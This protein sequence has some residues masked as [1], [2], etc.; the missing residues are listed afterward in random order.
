M[1]DFNLSCN[2][3]VIFSNYLFSGH[4]V[5]VEID[6]VRRKVYYLDLLG[7]NPNDEL[8]MVNEYV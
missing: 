7:D 1:N 6:M 4:W 5:L 3:F 8:Q 2:I